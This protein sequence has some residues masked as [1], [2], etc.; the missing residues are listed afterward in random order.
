MHKKDI[1]AIIMAAGSGSRMGAGYP[2]QFIELGGKTVLQRTIEKFIDAIPDVK[3]I[4]VLPELSIQTWKD[5]CARDSFDCPQMI[6]KGGITR[7][8]SVRNAMAKVPDGAIVLIHDG[9]RP[10]VSSELIASMVEMSEHYDALIPVIAVVDTLRSIDPEIPNPDR[11]KLV[12]V[13]T[14]QVFHSEKIKYAY[15]QAYKT[16]FTDDAS[17]AS[18]AGI[19]VMTTEGERFNIKLTTP[20]DLLLAEFLIK[21][22]M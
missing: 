10:F 3:F 5:I 6:V 12:A 22:N 21:N 14:P 15:N 8:Q 13:Q 20:E 9:V 7:F 2:K 18:A 11:S 17:V 1:Y 19:K 4:T 16:S